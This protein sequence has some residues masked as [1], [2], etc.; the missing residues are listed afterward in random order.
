[1]AVEIKIRKD[2][3]DF[4]LKMDFSSEDNRIGILG[5]SGCGKTMTLKCIAGIETPD[6]GRIVIGDR[7]F[8]DSKKKINLPARDRKIGYLFQN[9]ALFPHMTVE[10]NIGVGIRKKGPEKAQKIK[11]LIE[12]FQLNGLEKRYPSEL[13]GGQQQRTA[14]ARILACDP[15]MILLDEPFS[16]LDG[17]LKENMQQEMLKILRDYEGNV[18]MVS[19]SRDEIYRF[20]KRLVIMDRGICLLEGKTREIFRNPRK[21]EAARLTGCKNITEIKK[22]GKRELWAE[23]WGMHL[24]TQEEISDKISYVGIRAHDLVE[25]R[26]GEENTFFMEMTGQI[27]A[28]FENIYHLKQKGLEENTEEIWWKKEGNIEIEEIKENFPKY[29][30]LPKEKLLLLE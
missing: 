10:A 6:E 8:F 27:Q 11:D 23:K 15:D 3:G 24:V 28:P 21:K 1:M 22:T 26:E 19:H 16:A 13:S 17:F 7:V 5:A 20:S 4:V 30:Q 14:L 29:I 9:Y 18:M 2:F 12:K 25:S